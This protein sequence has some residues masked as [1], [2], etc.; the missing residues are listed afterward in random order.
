MPAKIINNQDPKTKEYLT[1]IGEVVVLL[2]HLESWVDFW[3]WELINANGNASIK[4]Q[5]GRRITSPLDFKQKVQL[6]MS[7]FVER[8]GEVKAKEFKEVAKSIKKCCDIRNDLAHSQ[9]FIQYGNIKEGISPTTQKIN[10]SKFLKS[11]KPFNFSKAIKDVE[12]SELDQYA[13]QAN[14]VIEKL[15]NFFIH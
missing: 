14:L 2:N 1:K 12:L 3:I 7:L 5:I 4:Q 13:I 8:C 11:T 10:I 9:W 15:T 6:L